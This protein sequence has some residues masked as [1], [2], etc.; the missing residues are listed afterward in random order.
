MSGACQLRACGARRGNGRRIAAEGAV[1]EAGAGLAA[2][3]GD[4]AGVHAQH[5]GR[6]RHF[7]EALALLRGDLSKHVLGLNVALMW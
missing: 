3:A 5:G 6:G 2:L 7:A 4:V 1:V